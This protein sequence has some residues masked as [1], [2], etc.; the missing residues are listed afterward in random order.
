MS[1]EAHVFCCSVFLQTSEAYDVTFGMNEL[2]CSFYHC[3]HH[4]SDNQPV[5]RGRCVW[6]KHSTF[7]DIACENCI[8]LYAMQIIHI[9]SGIRLT[10]NLMLLNTCKMKLY[11]W[12]VYV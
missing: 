7:A 11:W 5:T 9:S 2:S 1:I 6:R 3:A 10:S 8:T 12:D 4:S